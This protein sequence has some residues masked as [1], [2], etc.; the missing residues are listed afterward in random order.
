MFERFVIGKRRNWKRRALII[1]SAVLHGGAVAAL[2][3]ASWFRVVELTPPLLSIVFVPTA[4][5]QAAAQSKPSPSPARRAAHKAA[6]TQPPSTPQPTA[7]TEPKDSG[8][9][10]LGPPDGPPDAPPAIGPP[11]GGTPCS[12]AGCIAAPAPKPRNLPPHALDAQRLLGALPHL[13]A[14]VIGARRG[15]G[16]TTFTARLCV[17]Q[18]GAISSVTVLSGIPG[19]DADI[20]STLRGWHYKPQPLPVCFVTQLVYDVQ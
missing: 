6:L 1:G 10:E 19:G 17:D 11:G 9:K 14:A 16:D 2:V 4:P 13:P 5:P 3:I 8:G 7:T 15:L 12:G 18:S 20:V